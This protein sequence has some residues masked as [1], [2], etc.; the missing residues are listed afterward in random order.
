VYENDS[1]L[2]T[3]Q[4]D[5]TFH[6]TQT[7][8]AKISP[9][10]PSEIDMSA[11]RT[12]PDSILLSLGERCNLN[13]GT[14]VVHRMMGINGDKVLIELGDGEVWDSY[15]LAW[16]SHILKEGDPIVYKN[17]SDEWVAYR[18]DAIFRGIEHNMIELSPVDPPINQSIIDFSAAA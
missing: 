4:I 2:L 18:I 15:I 9:I 6:G 10:D 12:R 3:Y 11:L 5:A 1:G 14:V 16:S 8:M 17:N 7:D 13:D